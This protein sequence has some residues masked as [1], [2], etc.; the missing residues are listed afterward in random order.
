V[1]HKT[2]E[3][4]DALGVKTTQIGSEE[5]EW[6]GNRSESLKSVSDDLAA[7]LVETVSDLKKNMETTSRLT[8]LSRVEPDAS[9]F[10]SPPDI[11]S[12]QLLPRCHSRLAPGPAKALT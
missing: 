8:D 6:K 10:E 12:I 5:D 4:I 11:K 1:G 2:I 7:T 9:L 3:G